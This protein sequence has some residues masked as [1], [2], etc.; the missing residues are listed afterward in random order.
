ME[1]TLKIINSL[2]RI[3]GH[4]AIVVILAM[5]V[6]TVADVFMRFL[7]SKPITGTTEITEY[8]M[9]CIL[10][11]MAWAAVEGKHITVSAVMD[12]MPQKVQAFTDIVTFI[13]SLGVFVLVAWQSFI[14]SMFAFE[15]NVSSALL[16]LPD[17]PFYLVLM[18]CFSILC[19]AIL[20]ILVNRII[21]VGKK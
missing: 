13:I 15:F 1:E 11:A 19:L 5:M 12:R 18:V 9:V 21:Q 8:M 10:L 16:K 14:A 4:A 2:S 17:A 6:L 7:F 20:P 3:L